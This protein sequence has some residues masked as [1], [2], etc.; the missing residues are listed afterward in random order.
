MKGFVAKSVLGLVC[1][2]RK[3][4]PGVRPAAGIEAVVQKKICFFVVPCGNAINQNLSHLGI[5]D[6][7]KLQVNV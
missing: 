2:C 4:R 5:R 3:C 7:Q 1:C 6:L